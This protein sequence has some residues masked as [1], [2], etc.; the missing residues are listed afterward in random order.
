MLEGYV[1]AAE[2]DAIISGYLLSTDPQRIAW[3]ALSTADKEAYLNQALLRIESLA[4]IGRKA[5]D[6]QPLQFPRKWRTEWQTAPPEA[7]KE[8]QALEACASVGMTEEAEKR[9]QLKAQG[10][11]SF[12]AGSLSETYGNVAIGVNRIYSQI[13]RELLK[14]YLLG[15]V[16]FA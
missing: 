16:P 7:V 11:T 10:I 13:A 1:T 9:A 5:E 3:T 4:Y 15:A 8:A 14:P 6:D 2:A 12:S